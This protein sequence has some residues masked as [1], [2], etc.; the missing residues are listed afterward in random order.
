M[1][2]SLPCLPTISATCS[3]LGTGTH[4]VML[5][6][7]RLFD[8]LCVT[9]VVPKDSSTV[10]ATMGPRLPVDDDEDADDG[11]EVTAD[12]PSTGDDPIHFAIDGFD[13]VDATVT[14]AVSAADDTVIAAGG[15]LFR[16]T[17]A[18]LTRSCRANCEVVVAV[19]PEDVLGAIA[20]VPADD[21]SW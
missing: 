9:V 17:A 15:D 13:D 21:T 6:L 20:H 2:H 19:P 10:D 11:D 16:F 4:S 14:L 1:N 18:K 8:E 5:A 3:E 7:L 12:R